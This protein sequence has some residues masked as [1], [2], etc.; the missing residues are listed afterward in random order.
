LQVIAGGSF[1]AK[2]SPVCQAKWTCLEIAQLLSHV[3]ASRFWAKQS[4]VYQAS[5]TA[6][7]L[8]RRKER[9]SQ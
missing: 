6:W 1:S 2:R 7:G 4:P 8:L 9:S 5:L 3:I